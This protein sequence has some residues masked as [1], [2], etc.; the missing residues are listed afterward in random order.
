MSKVPIKPINEGYKPSLTPPDFKGG[1]QGP[2]AAPRNPPSGG[3]SVKPP[4][5]KK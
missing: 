2:T 1:Y 3:S 5:A 4:P